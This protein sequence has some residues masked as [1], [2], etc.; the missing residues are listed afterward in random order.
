MLPVTG[1][2][3]LLLCYFLLLFFFLPLTYTCC[4]LLCVMCG[5]IAKGFLMH[6]L[7]TCN[8]GGHLL[9]CLL[10]YMGWISPTLLFG[11]NRGGSS[12]FQ[13]LLLWSSYTQGGGCDPTT[14]GV[15]CLYY[16][17]IYALQYNPHALPDFHCYS[18]EET[19]PSYLFALWAGRPLGFSPVTVLKQLPDRKSVV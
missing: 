16:V 8:I 3:N 10:F 12:R 5:F 15:L 1:L 14:R 11:T 17:N 13:G 4:S 9:W 6:E 18:L 2:G 19:N 7:F